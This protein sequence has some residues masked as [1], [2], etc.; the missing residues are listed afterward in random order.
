MSSTQLLFE[1]LTAFCQSDSLS[2]IGLR[3]IIERHNWTPNREIIERHDAP[4]NDDPSINDDHAFFL[5]VCRNEKVTEGILR[6]L[7]EN[8]P[9]AAIQQDNSRRPPLLHMILY[10]NKNVTLGMVQLLV[11]AFPWAGRHQSCIKTLCDNNNLDDSIGL[12]ILKLLLERCPESVRHYG[13]YGLPI[14][15]AAMKQSPEFCRLLIEA[16]PGSEQMTNFRRG[17]QLPFH[18]ACQYNTVTTAKYLYQ[19]YPESI[20][21]AGDPVGKCPIHHAIWSIRKR[22]DNPEAAVTMVEFLIDCEPNVVSQQFRGKLPIYYVCNWATNEDAPKLNAALKVLQILYDAYPEAIESDEVTSNV[23][24]FCQEVQTFINTQLTYARQAR[25]QTNM[26]IPD[27]NGQLPLHRALRDNATLGS[28]KLLVKG[29]SSASA[30]SCPD[31]TGTM[32]LHIACQHHESASVIEYLINLDPTSLRARDFEHNTSL[33][34][35]CRGANHK[36]ITLLLEKYDGTSISKRNAHNQLPI[37]LLLESN[38]AEAG[39]REGIEY[40]ESVYRLIRGYPVIN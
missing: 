32:P 1:E 7:L 18:F 35:A 9:N 12:E 38:V 2:E 34:H 11:D 39:D 26:T 37:H 36:I 31:N 33:H 17:G 10:R 22:D 19:L 21:V 29:N 15:C 3:E 20:N 40:T 24:S 8:F 27:E 23:G 28:I 16:H 14:H 30:V 6:Y 25:D 5:E 4:D 13:G